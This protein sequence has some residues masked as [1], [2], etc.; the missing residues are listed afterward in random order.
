MTRFIEKL[1]E[2]AEDYDAIVLDQ[3]GVL[4]DGKT[5]YP[6]S[7]DA[8]ERLHAM[9]TRLAVLSNSGKRADLNAARIASKGFP[10]ALFEVVMT[11]G[12]ALYR[13]IA[14]GT[15]TEQR[16][17]PI[18]GS[19]GDAAA[20]ADDLECDLVASLE[21]ADAVLLMGLP[22]ADDHSTAQHCLEVARARGLPVYCS[23]P[24]RKSPRGGGYVT[25]PGALAHAYADAGGTVR[26]YGKPHRPVYDALSTALGSHNLL[27]VGDSLE[28]D[29]AGAQ[30][31]GWDSLF[32]RG[33]IHA[34][35]F[36]SGDLSRNL[37]QLVAAEGAPTPTYS[38]EVLK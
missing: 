21:L 17:Y 12:E 31:A 30:A 14:T 3:W 38:I 9:G 34:P 36:A 16:F 6:G 19:P 20:W 4:H 7:V 35:D 10:D 22:D 2:I 25:S 32:V 13:D 1:A 26:F 37:A 27:M 23:N 33:G 5:P 8:L 15:I 24:D 29:I 11:S 18:Q 28:H